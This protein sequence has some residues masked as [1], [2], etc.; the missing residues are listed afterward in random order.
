MVLANIH[1][2]CEIKTITIPC[3]HIGQRKVKHV[4][5]LTYAWRKKGLE[6][7]FLKIPRALVLMILRIN[8]QVPPLHCTCWFK[9]SHFYSTS[10]WDITY[11]AST[12]I[13]KNVLKSIFFIRFIRWYIIHRY[14]LTLI[15]Y[16]TDRVNEL[17]SI[18]KK[19]S[20]KV[21]RL[22]AQKTW[23]QFSSWELELFWRWKVI[24][25]CPKAIVHKN[26]F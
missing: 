20:M 23:Y 7:P 26:F 5:G 17:V 24:A 16:T 25:K 10:K 9:V 14:A 19:L 13:G 11:W 22:E 3:M 15:R 6:L 21:L 18:L 8:W 1:I 12:M 2:I 4:R